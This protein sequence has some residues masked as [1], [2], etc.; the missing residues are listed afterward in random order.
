LLRAR[1]GDTAFADAVRAGGESGVDDATAYALGE[2]T[3]PKTAQIG[4]RAEHLLTRREQE[5]AELVAQGLKNKDIAVTL[6]IA[7]RTAEGHIEHIM[8]KLGFTSRAQI[9]SWVTE[10]SHSTDSS[11]G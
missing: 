3:T 8:R 10:Q 9:A 5:I 6:V 2:V 1:L 7:P 11:Q 4:P